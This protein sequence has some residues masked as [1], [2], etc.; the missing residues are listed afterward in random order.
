[1]CEIIER[2]VYDLKTEEGQKQINWFEE[3]EKRGFI[4]EDYIIRNG[5]KYKI[6]RKIKK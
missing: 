3:L 2:R 1:M 4:Q 6:F 5:K